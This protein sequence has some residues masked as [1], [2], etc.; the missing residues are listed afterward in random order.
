MTQNEI[1]SVIDSDVRTGLKGVGNFSYSIQMLEREIPVIRNRILKSAQNK[2][3]FNRKGF[4]QSINCIK[5][6]REKL[7]KCPI[8]LGDIDKDVLH[9]EIPMLLLDMLD[10]GIDYIGPSIKGHSRGWKVYFDD[11]YSLHIRKPATCHLPFIYIDPVS[12]GQK[13]HDG[14]IFNYKGNLR[15]LSFRGIINNPEDA[16]LYQCHGPLEDFPAPDWCVE[17]IIR[18]LTS[19]Y[20]QNYRQL[21]APTQSNTQNDNVS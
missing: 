7:S 2:I 10:E 11:G 3:G 12:T 17:E 14:F 19:K 1:A 9:F 16:E 21:H 8:P 6:D 5:V 15:N 4:L 20:I 18:R 13:T